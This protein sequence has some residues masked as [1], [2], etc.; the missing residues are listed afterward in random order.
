MDYGSYVA[1]ENII[2]R[3]LRGL[4]PIGKDGYSV[5]LHHWDGIARDFNNYSPITRTLHRLI[6]HDASLFDSF[7]EYWGLK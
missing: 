5:E 7:L 4:A 1:T 3:M 6:H 2:N